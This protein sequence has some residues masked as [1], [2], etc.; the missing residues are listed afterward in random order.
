[1]GL[2][3]SST[4]SVEAILTT[5]GKELLSTD[6]TVNITK[7]ALGDEEID[8]TLYD[9]THP[10]GT[11]SFGV[12]LENTIPLETSPTRQNLKS[13]LL[14]DGFSNKKLVVPQSTTLDA[15]TAFLIK[16]VTNV[17]GNLYDETYLFKIDNTKIVSFGFANAPSQT[18]NVA[19]TFSGIQAAV[20]GNRI[21]PGAT[22]LITVEGL[23]THLKEVIVVTVNAD[24]T[25]NTLSPFDETAVVTDAKYY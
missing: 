16:P 1:M 12:V 6:G 4:L 5:R 18:K 24:S 19:K 21:N 17:D 15:D 20:R 9:K 7:F 8:Y 14:N 2:Y 22:T 3:N 10:N 25:N 11:D 23:D 13:Y